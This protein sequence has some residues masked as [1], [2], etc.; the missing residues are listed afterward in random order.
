MSRGP[1]G[2]IN[3]AFVVYPAK[4]E[5]SLSRVLRSVDSKSVS[6]MVAEV[7]EGQMVCITVPR[8]EHGAMDARLRDVQ[9][10][11]CDSR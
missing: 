10:C 4:P 5:S 7:D 8:N 9:G 2:W 11:H 1:L 6:E 3:A